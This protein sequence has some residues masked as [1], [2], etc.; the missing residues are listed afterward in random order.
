MISQAAFFGGA[1]YTTT[2]VSVTIFLTVAASHSINATAPGL[3]I[4]LASARQLPVGK[5]GLVVNDGAESFNLIDNGNNLIAV[6][7]PG[8]CVDLCL[9]DNTTAAGVWWH[10]LATVGIVADP[11]PNLRF[12]LV[13][14]LPAGTYDHTQR[15]YDTQA[16]VWTQKS[17]MPSPVVQIDAGAVA[18]VGTSG[19]WIG[20]QGGT[21]SDRAGIY[22]YDPD[23]WTQR[24]SSVDWHSECGAVTIGSSLFAFNGAP[25]NAYHTNEYTPGSDAWTTRTTRPT[26]RRITDPTC[27]FANSKAVLTDGDSNAVDTYVVDTWTAKTGRPGA[28][29]RRCSTTSK[30]NICYVYGG[31]ASSN[32]IANVYTYD[33]SIDTW[34]ALTSMSTGREMVSACSIGDFNY[35]AGGKEGPVG[36]SSNSSATA[37][38]AT[39]EHDPVSDSYLTKA[40][41]FPVPP[42]TQR[43]YNAMNQGGA[44]AP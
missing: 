7:A 31:A 19:Y 44:V 12:Y 40:D 23:T 14:G 38:K 4:K 28:S 25:F 10:Q 34:A 32:F 30:A 39:V 42:A 41:V 35:L 5:E 37:T 3:N 29:A 9:A 15:E 17:D 1:R 11:G 26:G 6:V 27:A 43:V 8:E 16:D 18:V 22:Q 20:V 33:E 24:T 36:T 2:G 21:G 13:G